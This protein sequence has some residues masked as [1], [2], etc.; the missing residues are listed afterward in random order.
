MSVAGEFHRVLRDYCE[1][2]KA[3]EA[4]GALERAQTLD[5][6]RESAADDLS[7]AAAAALDVC[8]DGLESAAF[9]SP[10]EEARFRELTEHFVAICHVILGRPLGGG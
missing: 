5:G 4:G 6:L 8:G 3:S 9:E 1:F 7:R 2:L 10:T